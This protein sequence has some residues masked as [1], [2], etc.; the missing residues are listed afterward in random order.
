MRR[1][2][3]PIPGGPIPASSGAPAWAL[4]GLSL[5]ML[6]SSLGTSVANVALPTLEVTFGA[7]F[8]Q[9]RWV[10]LAYLLVVTTLVVSAGRLGDLMGRRRLLLAGVGTFTCSSAVGAAAPE[11]WM[12]IVA[13]GL[14]GA[15]AAAMMALSLAFVA[16]TVPEGRTGRA[17]GLLGSASAVGTALGPSLG[18]LLIAAF[19]WRA[20]FLL[21][22]PLGLLALGLAHRHLPADRPLDGGRRPRFDL[23]GTHLLI[24]TL[25]AYAL[26][27]TSPSARVTT[28]LIVAGIAGAVLLVRTERRA[29]APLISGA[30]LRDP[31]LGPGLVTSAV[32]ST[33]MMATLV[34]GPFHLS[35]A[36]GLGPAQVGLVMSAGPALVALSGV[37]AGRIADRLG[38]PRVTRAGLVGM[39]AGTL[40]LSL[41]PPAFGVPG[42]LGPILLVTLGYALFQTANN[43]AVMAG[44]DAERRG[45]TSGMLNLSRNLGLITG[46][47]V[48]GTVFARFS[49]AVAVS[50]A[51]PH[52]VAAGM[53][54]TFVLAT[55]LIAG[56]TVVSV[57]GDARS[58]DVG[59]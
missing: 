5:V 24:L 6:L 25:G 43:T 18:G 20:I 27:M 29:E 50:D 31:V 10:V 53:R 34:V 21:N 12:L 23:A 11:L 42:Y 57:R 4:A 40:L 14:Q 13:R 32:V 41:I 19:D 44:S 17:M 3:H 15:G 58:T 30:V 59:S 39:A 48:M 16:D 55:V 2:A 38:A 33:V 37:P 52:D 46:A 56:A 8:G 54:A 35:R 28:V 22:V 1:T 26:A 49:G 47:A 36:L 9:V 45:A 51:A 7:S